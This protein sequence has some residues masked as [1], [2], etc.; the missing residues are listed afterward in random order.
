MQETFLV[1]KD[2]PEEQS[3]QRNEEQEQQGNEK[4]DR[5]EAMAP[6]NPA[7]AAAMAR[8]NAPR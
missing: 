4:S 1:P 8:A 3:E 2:V 5:E 7:L 6:T